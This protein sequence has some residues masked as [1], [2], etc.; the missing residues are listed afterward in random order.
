MK[1]D[2]LW[3]IFFCSAEL[4]THFLVSRVC[5]CPCR[6]LFKTLFVL[7]EV[8]RPCSWTVCG[9]S[10]PSW[11]CPASLSGTQWAMSH[12][13]HPASSSP[14]KVRTWTSCFTLLFPPASH[15][16]FA[17]G[18]LTLLILCR[19]IKL[20]HVFTHRM[21]DDL[22]WQLCNWR[23]C[24]FDK[25][26]G[27]LQRKNLQHHQTLMLHRRANHKQIM[28]FLWAAPSSDLQAL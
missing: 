23:D 18:V 8:G 13:L 16:W 25:C 11:H 14:S 12:W 4:R 24:G 28:Q 27:F 19:F 2:L 10:T 1:T 20:C 7:L 26:S 22:T 3:Q 15:S 17:T 9:R 6:D 5:F 21:T